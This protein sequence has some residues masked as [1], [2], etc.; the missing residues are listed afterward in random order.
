MNED[1]LI[2]K[3]REKYPVSI[4]EICLYSS[5]EQILGRKG[6][7]YTADERK[8]RWNRAKSF[9]DKNTLDYWT[10]SS[11]CHGC[12]HL[13]KKEA[14]CN[15]QGLPCTINPI[16]SFRYGMIGMA[17]MG[18]GFQHEWPDLFEEEFAA[19]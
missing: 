6:D 10:D 14:W 12:V 8:K 1:E 2:E 15:Y 13:N 3:A 7:V 11:G 19:F 4:D 18:V 9:F 5:F 17:C 16:L